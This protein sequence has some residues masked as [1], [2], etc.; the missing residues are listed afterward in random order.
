MNENFSGVIFRVFK[1]IQF[2]FSRIQGSWGHHTKFRDI[3]GFQGFQDLLDTPRVG[4]R[5]T[6]L[7]PRMS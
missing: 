5:D 4:A 2:R 7:K 1:T 3:H 6:K